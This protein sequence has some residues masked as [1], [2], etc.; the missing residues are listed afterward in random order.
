MTRTAILRAGYAGLGLAFAAI[1]G[2]IYVGSL[3]LPGLAVAL[4]AGLLLAFSDEDLPKWA[5]IALVVYFVLIVLVFLAA[6]PITIN[7]GDRYFVN[8]APPELARE[9]AY[10]LGLAAPLML[11]GAALVASWERERPAR[12]LLFGA[13]AGFILVGVLTVSLVPRT[14]LAGD[15]AVGQGNMIKTLFAVSAAAGAAGS[16]WAAGRADEFA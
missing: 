4:M 15:A 11:G 1:A 14:T 5:G 8:S 6:T 3:L 10:W 2:S 12:T 13:I 16:L 7:K 9:V